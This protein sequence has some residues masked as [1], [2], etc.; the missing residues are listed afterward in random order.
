MGKKAS[1]AK[2][3]KTNF[4]SIASIITTIQIYPAEAEQDIEKLR[5]AIWADLAPGSPY[6]EY[7]TEELIQRIL[8]VKRLRELRKYLLD[9]TFQDAAR[10][11][12]G[13]TS[14]SVDKATKETELYQKIISDVRD[15][16]VISEIDQKLKNY[17]TSLHLIQLD[18]FREITSDLADID[19]R[20]DLLEKKLRHVHQHLGSIQAARRR[21]LATPAS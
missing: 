3:H 14:D 8:E 17:E 15:A 19:K 7:V 11:A 18:A 16:A 2:S 9:V 5:E 1:K 12:L 13:L 10:K 20:L 6:E 21:T 4:E